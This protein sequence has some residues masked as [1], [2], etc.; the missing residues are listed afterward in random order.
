M[1]FVFS[2]G[3]TLLVAARCA[4][5]WKEKGAYDMQIQCL[6]LLA[7]GGFFRVLEVSQCVCVCLSSESTIK[8][9]TVLM[10]T[11]CVCKYVRAGSCCTNVSMG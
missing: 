7:L 10:W 5:I 6:L 3:Y 1:T 8:A 2:L 9:V 11:V 4:V